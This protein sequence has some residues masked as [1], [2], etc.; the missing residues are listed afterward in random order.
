[1]GFTRASR[2]YDF[3]R[4]RGSYV[5]VFQY[6]AKGGV[7]DTPTI[8]DIQL[9]LLTELFHNQDTTHSGSNGAD[10]Y[11]RVGAGWNF[12]LVLSFPARLATGG[13]VEQ[14]FAEQILGSLRTVA[15]RFYVGDPL[16]WKD[17]KLP[18]RSFY[19]SK[20]LLGNVEN[21][22]DSKGKE[23]VGIRMSG[24]GSSILYTQLNG[25]NQSPQVWF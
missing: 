24:V 5:E 7:S 10:L 13:D 1:M 17:L 22:F 14:P 20:A 2:E 4:A 16:F 12:A 11:T 3:V 23:V 25:V 21:R 9:G 6:D 18:V 19:G 15:L 8:F